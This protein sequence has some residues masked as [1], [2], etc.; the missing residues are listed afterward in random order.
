MCLKNSLA[1]S[2]QPV[3]GAGKPQGAESTSALTSAPTSTGVEI[4]ETGI[5]DSAGYTHY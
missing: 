5:K 3:S 2:G 1:Y 4:K